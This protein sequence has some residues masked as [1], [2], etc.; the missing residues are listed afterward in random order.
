MNH[1]VQFIPST[2]G[3]IIA[4][5]WLRS[6][7]GAAFGI[8]ATGAVAALFAGSS[9]SVFVLVAPIGAS[10]VLL[11]AVPASPLAQPWAI[12][13]GNFVSALVGITVL[14]AI[15][16]PVLAAG[17]AVGAAIAAM[18]LLRCLHPPGGA[19]ALTV[20]LGGSE[21]AQLGYLFALVP[22]FLNSALLAGA[23]LVY[24]RLTGRS[25][26]HRAHEHLEGDVPHARHA[27]AD[28]D[29][30]AV[31][32]GYGEALDI[33]RKDLESLYLELVA[34]KEEKRRQR[35]PGGM[36]PSSRLERRDA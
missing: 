13:G 25:Y 36:S 31:L 26:P 6:A 4:A 27:L 28:E 21:V 19:V 18:S 5:D 15:A 7:V 33:T 10:A 9:A 16:S 12:L 2:F 1:P 22:V 3:R 24:N 34:R 8:V 32:T 17:L 35:P 29:F 14:Q 20:V 23:A 11:F 30:D